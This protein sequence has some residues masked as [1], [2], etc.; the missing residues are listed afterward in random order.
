VL[1]LEPRTLSFTLAATSTAQLLFAEILNSRLEALAKVSYDKVVDRSDTIRELGLP[2]NKEARQRLTDELY[3]QSRTVL[4]ASGVAAALLT[5]AAGLV[6]TFFIARDERASAEAWLSF[7]FGV[8]A[9]GSFF[10]LIVQLARSR[11]SRYAVD[12]RA[13]AW[14][15]TREKEPH[16]LRRTLANLKASGKL[17]RQQVTRFHTL[18]PFKTSVILAAVVATA[19]GLQL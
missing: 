7:L 13:A 2:E 14:P 6:V 5:A 9:L 19:V 11:I 8:V 15:V 4:N 10:G 17:Y 16:V 12:E 3:V 18:T 1:E